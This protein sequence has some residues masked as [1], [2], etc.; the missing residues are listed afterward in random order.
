MTTQNRFPASSNN[1][2]SLTSMKLVKKKHKQTICNGWCHGSQQTSK[3]HSAL[4][5][6]T[7]LQSCMFCHVNWVL[8]T[9]TPYRWWSLGE[10]QNFVALVASNNDMLSECVVFTFHQTIGLVTIGGRTIPCPQ[11]FLGTVFYH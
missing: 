1:D 4:A 5:Q 6:I 10:T 2:I 3:S 7:L 9:S 11:M 8:L